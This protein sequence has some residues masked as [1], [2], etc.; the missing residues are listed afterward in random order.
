MRARFETILRF[1]VTKARERT[2]SRTATTLV[3]GGGLGGAMLLAAAF[4]AAGAQQGVPAGIA[5]Y[6]TWTKMNGILLNDPSNPR[7][8][9]KNTFI[10]LSRD[11]V[12][13]ITGPG[14]LVRKPYPDG[15]TIVRES[16]DPDAG[17]VRVL[18]VMRYD[19]T[20]T[21]TK[22]WV[23]SGYSRT[24]ADKPFQPL[25]IADP[26]A[27]CVNCHTQV[28]AADY[29]FTPNTVAGGLLPGPSSTV[30]DRVAMYNYQFGPQA[31]HVKA[32]TTVTFIN[33]DFVPH[34]VKAAD[35]SFESGNI[36]TYGIY[37]VTFTRPGTVAYFC[38]VHLGMR[39]SIVVEP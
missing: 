37:T 18:F 8:A 26:V 10:N 30:P 3:L 25:E 19:S 6:R 12:R 15:A 11:Q 22:K 7:A 20:A 17:F 16:L 35:R 33:D 27:R 38:A 21:K 9:P 36:P 24:A 4:F 31:L 39:G 5:Q 1:V 28:K 14:G 29:V 13:Q 2:R 32:G 23:Y 34:D